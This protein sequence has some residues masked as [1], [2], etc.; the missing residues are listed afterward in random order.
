MGVMVQI[1]LV[2]FFVCL[3]NA[4]MWRRD[5]PSARK[6]RMNNMMRALDFYRTLR[7]ADMTRYQVS[8]DAS[9]VLF[10]ILLFRASPFLVASGKVS[11]QSY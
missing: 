11:F 6:D 7:A 5:E 4:Q 3:T 9:K 8:K 2:V 1:S 10:L